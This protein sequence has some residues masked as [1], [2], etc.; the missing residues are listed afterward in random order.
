MFIN[1]ILHQ[2]RDIVKTS[3]AAC[4]AQFHRSGHRHAE[5][6]RSS[7][8]CCISTSATSKGPVCGVYVSDAC[9]A[10][11]SGAGY[12]MFMLKTYGEALVRYQY[13]HTVHMYV[14]PICHSS[15]SP[16]SLQHGELSVLLKKPTCST[17]TRTVNGHHILGTCEKF[18]RSCHSPVSRGELSWRTL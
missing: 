15:A 7:I 3:C 2:E 6:L 4:R 10:G 11:M 14:T 8:K 13:V 9:T 5:R 1:D 17:Y 18:F 12:A 16:N